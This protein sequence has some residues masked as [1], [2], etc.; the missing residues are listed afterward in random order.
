MKNVNIKRLVNDNSSAIQ[1]WFREER[2][3]YIPTEQKL[4]PMCTQVSCY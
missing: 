2:Q 1:P 4:I 3:E